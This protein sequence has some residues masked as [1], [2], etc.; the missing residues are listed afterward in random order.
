MKQSN[1]SE[2]LAESFVEGHLRISAFCPSFSWGA[3]IDGCNTE[4]P[5][6]VC[7]AG[8]E[9]AFRWLLCAMGSGGRSCVRY[10]WGFQT[11][12]GWGEGLCFDYCVCA[13]EILFSV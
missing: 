5:A 8:M 6:H 13:L 7:P 3:F 12:E 11:D 2:I 1:R 10:G 4:L 9:A